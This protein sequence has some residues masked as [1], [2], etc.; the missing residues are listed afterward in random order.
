M[1]KSVFEANE[2]DLKKFQEWIAAQPQLPKDMGSFQTYVDNINLVQVFVL[3]RQASPVTL[4]KSLQ[5]RP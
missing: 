4:P 2:E 3:I 1:E 5:L